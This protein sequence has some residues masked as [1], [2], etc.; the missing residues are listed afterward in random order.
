MMDSAIPALRSVPVGPLTAEDF[1]PFGQVVWMGDEARRVR[2]EGA[3]ERQPEAVE[4]RLWV[5][6]IKQAV[7]LPLTVTTMERHPFSAQTFVPVN[8]C[9]YLVIVCH[10]TADGRPDPSTLRAFEAAPD[11]GVT[12][13]RDVWHHGLAA[14]QAPAKFVVCMTFSGQ[15]DDVFTPLEHPVRVLAPEHP[16]A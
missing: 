3:F 15:D 6:T 1:A 5:A 2:V 14:L 11:Q 4:P 7:A 10:A 16:H 13:A 12:Y 9:A 8:G